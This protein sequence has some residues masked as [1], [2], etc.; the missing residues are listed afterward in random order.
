M[1][2]AKQVLVVTFVKKQFSQRFIITYMSVL[3]N[4]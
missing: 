3:A 2:F 4:I 1:D